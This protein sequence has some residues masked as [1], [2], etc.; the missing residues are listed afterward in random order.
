MYGICDCEPDRSFACNCLSA[1]AA[2]AT[3]TPVAL[4]RRWTWT[5]FGMVTDLSGGVVHQ[6]GP[7]DM[8]LGYALRDH[9]EINTTDIR[10]LV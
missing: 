10:I 5:F 6:T 2:R 3:A 7:V 4:D 1:Y 8:T 9:L